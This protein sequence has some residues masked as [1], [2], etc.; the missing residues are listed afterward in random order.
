MIT[1][2]TKEYIE[3]KKNEGLYGISF[4]IAEHPG[5][6]LKDEIAHLGIS[7][8]QF[9]VKIGCTEQTISRI[10]NGK[11]PIT[12]DM[13]VKL[14]VIF[15]GYPSAEFWNNMQKSYDLQ[16]LRNEMEIQAENDISFFD[17]NLKNTFSELK[18]YGFM[19]NIV[20]RGKDSKI[21]AILALKKWFGVSNLPLVFEEDNLKVA[22]RKYQREIKDNYAVAGW[23]RAGTLKTQEVFSRQESVPEYDNKKFIEKVAS[24][25]NLSIENQTIFLERLKKELFEC[26]VL[27]VYLPGFKNAHIGGVLKWIKGHPVIMLKTYKQ[28]EDVFWFNLF[29]EI[30]HIVK[31]SKKDFF[32][33]F[34]E[35]E[36]ET[37][38][39]NDEKEKEANIFAKE[40]LLPSLNEIKDELN[41]CQTKDLDSALKSVA[42]INN[43]SVSVLA[44]RLC[45]EFYQASHNSLI[46]QRLDKY[47]KTI[48]VMGDNS[49]Y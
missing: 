10:V 20:A 16:Y 4:D 9:S 29:H 19:P 37:D 3:K 8:L 33:D 28:R 46:W 15:G 26:G 7:Q 2:N 40:M 35:T 45:H 39:E 5:L 49:D 42:K 6:T 1:K 30:G 17:E 18:H 22:F 27:I 47:R 13:A 25:K 24:L 44:G 48:E 32:V 43:V 21:K 14:E 11:E 31:H 36:S 38:S 34:K 41:S 12:S 23:V